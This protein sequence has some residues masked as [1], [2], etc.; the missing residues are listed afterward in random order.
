MKLRFTSE[1]KADLERI[2]DAIAV[3]NPSRALSFVEELEARCRSLPD[4]P[5]AY[6]LVSRKR[7]KGI[8]RLVHGNY[9]IFYRVDQDAIVIVHILAARMNVNDIM[10]LSE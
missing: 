8:R 1:A 6:P 5:L 10:R 3:D 2:G 9:L 4:T 7:E